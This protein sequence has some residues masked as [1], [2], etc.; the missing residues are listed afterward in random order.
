MEI[1]EMGGHAFK[2]H[3][4]IEGATRKPVG[5]LER[6]SVPVTHHRNVTS[7]KSPHTMPKIC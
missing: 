6:E 7:S 1:M 5:D 4:S 3:G 2:D